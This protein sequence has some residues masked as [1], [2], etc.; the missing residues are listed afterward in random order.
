[1]FTSTTGKQT[2]LAV[3]PEIMRIAKEAARAY[4]MSNRLN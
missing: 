1:M 4:R 2:Y 3:K